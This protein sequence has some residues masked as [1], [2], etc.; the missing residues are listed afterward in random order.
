MSYFVR[1]RLRLSGVRLGAAALLGL[2]ICLTPRALVAAPSEAGSSFAITSID[3]AD[4]S[5]HIY[6]L[7][8]NELE[9]RA[10]GTPGCN[11]AAEYI[12]SEFHRSGVKPMGD[13]GTFFQNFMKGDLAVKNVAGLLPGTDPAVANEILVI[14]AH[15]DHVG[16]GNFGSAGGASARGEIHNGA[17]DN[18]SG[19]SGVLELAQAFSIYPPRRP[20]LFLLFTG[21]DM[22]LVGSRYYCEH[23]LVPLEHTIAM[24][25]MDMI[26]RSRER[27]LFIGGVGTSPIFKPMIERLN[28]DFG[29]HL[30]VK[31]GGRAPSD[32]AS[33]YVKRM[34]VLFFFTNVHEDYHR[35]GDDWEK[36]DFATARDITRFIFRIAQET[37][38]A[39]ERPLF[40][41][42]EG[43]ALPDS[44]MRPGSFSRPRTA[45]LG[46]KPEVE[47]EKGDGVGIEA[48]VGG[49]AA[50]KAGLLEGDRILSMDGDPV[51]DGDRLLELIKRTK[52]GQVVRLRIRRGLTEQVI[53][54]TIGER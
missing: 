48:I 21:E 41:P 46:V 52:P 4:L 38:N 50:E 40:T 43:F 7:A 53:E 6:F 32:N 13:E 23:P 51:T 15:H 35:P 2:G 30:E 11:I 49:S 19:T 44:M 42:S 25:N 39:A 3:N 5:G 17:D 45:Y 16:R 27:Y 24:F 34:P 9:G 37:A 26:G 22:G 12:A 29:F 14:G 20:I 31:D 36:I 18:A 1:A 28:G 33:F 10:A 8:S 47:S 54:A